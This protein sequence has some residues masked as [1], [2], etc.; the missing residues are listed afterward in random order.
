MSIVFVYPTNTWNI[1]IVKRRPFHHHI[2]KLDPATAEMYDELIRGEASVE[3][4]WEWE[5]T[6]ANGTVY[7]GIGPY[8]YDITDL[9]FEVNEKTKE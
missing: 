3:P 8:I 7:A 4:I 2:T 9:R 1:M 5:T 6:L